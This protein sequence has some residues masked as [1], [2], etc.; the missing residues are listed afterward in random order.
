MPTSLL[1]SRLLDP[2]LGEDAQARPI[3][4]A[5]NIPLPD[6]PARTYELPPKS[7]LIE[8]VGPADLSRQA[9]A[10]LLEQGRLAQV[11]P[12]F[13]YAEAT[14][15]RHRLWEPNAFLEQVLPNLTPGHALDLACGSGR[16]A[17]ALATAGWRVTAVDI[18]P[19]ALERG[20][21]L[22]HRYLHPEDEHN[23]D[24]IE[25]DLEARKVEL[26]L[27]FDLIVSFSYLHRPLL[28]RLS[29]WLQP[30]GSIVLETFTTVHRE[31]YAKPSSD[32]HILQP[33]ELLN[34]AEGLAVRHYSEDWRGGRHT[35]RLW[36]QAK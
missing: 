10:L 7:E 6:L 24:W 18:L 34:Y 36:A 22:A 25:R 19:D 32:R 27:N 1:A 5:V 14:D 20:R 21:L 11:Q 28:P 8:V 23:I 35:A 15:S 29:D 9:V 12:S 17:V 3:V 26:G 16:E 30:G 31:R 33:G 13:V 4:R 2:R